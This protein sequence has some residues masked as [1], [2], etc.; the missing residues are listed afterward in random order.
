MTLTLDTHSIKK[1]SVD[2]AQ[3]LTRKMYLYNYIFIDV[4]NKEINIEEGKLK[5]L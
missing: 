4:T 1:Y 3:I 5:G 2:N